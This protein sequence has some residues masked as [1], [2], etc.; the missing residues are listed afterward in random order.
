MAPRANPPKVCPDIQ[1]AYVV[2]YAFHFLAAKGAITYQAVICTTSALEQ[3]K[4]HGLLAL[5][6]RG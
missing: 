3:A 4:L 1:L 5:C 2:C 6:K